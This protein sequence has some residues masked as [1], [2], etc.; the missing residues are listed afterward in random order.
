[1]SDL[2][3]SDTNIMSKLQR[4]LRVKFDGNN[5]FSTTKSLELLADKLPKLECKSL[6]CEKVDQ[7][8]KEQIGVATICID[9]SIVC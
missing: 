4:N 8:K 9:K 3:V 1:M 5:I 2:G 7:L 6:L